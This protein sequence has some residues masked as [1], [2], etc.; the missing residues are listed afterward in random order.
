MKRI[1]SESAYYVFFVDVLREG[2]AETHQFVLPD[3]VLKYLKEVLNSPTTEAIHL[4]S[5][6]VSSQDIR[7]NSPKSP[8]LEI[9]FTL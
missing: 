2:L 3:H 8:N 4:W 5:K 6:T 1:K 7:D 9:K